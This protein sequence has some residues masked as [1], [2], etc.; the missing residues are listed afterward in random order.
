MNKIFKVGSLIAVMCFAVISLQAQKFG[1]V[2]SQ[3]ILAEMPDVKQAE[4]NLEALQKQLEKKLQ[5]GLTKLQQDYVAIQQKVER[6]ELSPKQQEEE[7]KKLQDRQTQL[8]QDEQNMVQQIQKKRADE[9]NPILEKVNKAI[10]D[11]AKENGFQF[12]FEQGVLLYFEESQDVSSMVK[13]K[14]NM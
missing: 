2:N 7:A 5:D 4:A 13:A 11:V 10:A 14:L 6:G 8:Q 12:I 1:Y 3:A 9:L